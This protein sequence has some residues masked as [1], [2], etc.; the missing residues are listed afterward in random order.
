MDQKLSINSHACFNSGHNGSIYSIIATDVL[1]MHLLDVS[2]KDASGNVLPRA[3][4]LNGDDYAYKTLAAYA[5]ATVLAQ[6]IDEMRENAKDCYVYES[7]SP[8]AGS[9][10]DEQTQ[11]DSNPLMRERNHSYL[12]YNPANGFSIRSLSKDTR[13]ISTRTVAGGRIARVTHDEI[14]TNT[15]IE[16]LYEKARALVAE[17]VE[18]ANVT[19]DALLASISNDEQLSEQRIHCER[20]REALLKS[21]ERT[22]DVDQQISYIK[23]YIACRVMHE[24]NSNTAIYAP[25]YSYGSSKNEVLTKRVLTLIGSEWADIL[26]ALLPGTNVNPAADRLATLNARMHKR[27]VT[28]ETLEGIEGEESLKSFDVFTVPLDFRSTK[29]HDPHVSV[30][31]IVNNDAAL[32]NINAALDVYNIINSVLY[33]LSNYQESR[34]SHALARLDKKTLQRTTGVHAEGAALKYAAANAEI[35]SSYAG[36]V[37]RAADRVQHAVNVVLMQE[38]IGLRHSHAMLTQRVG[39]AGHIMTGGAGW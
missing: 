1:R 28:P 3:H 30:D 32:D 12:N 39:A 19:I 9:I 2:P 27:S 18:S 25:H 35:D 23:Q 38:L 4:Y 5:I 14:S 22:D 26:Q 7:L 36:A 17:M 20:W 24:K 21:A 29:T 33:A 13:F 15:I 8:L 10:A 6:D 16:R 11:R 37:R 31:H 34:I